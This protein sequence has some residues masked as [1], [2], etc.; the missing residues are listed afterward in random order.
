[1][2]TL[3]QVVAA[4]KGVSAQH[5]PQAMLLEYRA[6]TRGMMNIDRTVSLSRRDLSPPEYR[7]T[8]SDVWPQPIN[9]WLDRDRLPVLNGG[10]LGA[11][12]YGG[13]PRIIDDLRV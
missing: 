1:M 8:R 4:L 11:L 12:L 3:E 7:I 10:L 13:E 6:A 9:P 5:D 2:D